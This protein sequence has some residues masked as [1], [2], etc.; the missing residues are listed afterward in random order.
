MW[1]AGLRGAMAYALALESFH[2]YSTGKVMLVITLV[3]ALFSVMIIGSIFNPLITYLNIEKTDEDLQTQIEMD[4]SFYNA[5]EFAK[6]TN[7]GE[8]LKM[9]L[10]KFNMQYFKPIFVVNKE[11]AENIADPLEDHSTVSKPQRKS[12]SELYEL[13]LDNNDLRPKVMQK[14]LSLDSKTQNQNSN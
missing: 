1:V 3:Y 11:E 5:R 13:D 4:E 2:D 9:K 10:F 8:K 12:E 6:V 14:R 7:W